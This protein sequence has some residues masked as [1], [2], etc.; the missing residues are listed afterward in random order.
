MTRDETKKVLEVIDN[1]YPNWHPK[2]PSLTLS[3]WAA[4][5][6]DYSYKD[7]GEALRRYIVSDRQGFAPV[8]GQLVDI[9]HT[10]ED[11]SDCT[12][13]S[14]W[15]MVRKAISN[16]NYGS[17]EEFD[18]LPA[19]VQKAVGSPENIKEWAMMDTEAVDSV[20]QSNF[21]RAYRTVLQRER[22][23]RRYLLPNA[24]NV[25]E[26][27]QNQQ[28][29]ENKSMVDI[30]RDMQQGKPEPDMSNEFTRQLYK[31][32]GKKPTEEAV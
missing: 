21:L 4:L 19:A 28:L 7:V 17:R 22:E 29:T 10:P 16:G 24:E 6:K 15:S 32:F 9:L 30:I 8:P 1:V 31:R 27:K 18:K 2:D 20:I 14:A 3:V 13:L 12:D 11:E 5:F 26:E 25:I 23:K